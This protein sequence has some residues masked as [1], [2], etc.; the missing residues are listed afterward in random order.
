MP[1]AKCD[2]TLSAKT[3]NKCT[4]AYQLRAARAPP[5]LVATLWSSILT[6]WLKSNW[7]YSGI[8]TETIGS[9]HKQQHGKHIEATIGAAADRRD[10]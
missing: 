1:R 2:W 8:G 9:Y 5:A 10:G 6:F 7:R 4:R 3:D